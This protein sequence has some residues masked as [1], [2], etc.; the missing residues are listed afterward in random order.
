MTDYRFVATLPELIPPE[1]Y[2]DDP[3]GRRVRIR[4]GVVDGR[5]EVLGDA[6]RAETLEHLLEALGPE[7]IEQMLCG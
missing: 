2:P 3:E 4:I 5:L 6:A 7:A 1:E